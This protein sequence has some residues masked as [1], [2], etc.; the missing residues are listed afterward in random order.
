MVRCDASLHRSLAPRGR[1]VFETGALEK[2]RHIIP[3][4]GGE[5]PE[6]ERIRSHHRR[7]AAPPP[8][9]PKMI[10]TPSMKPKLYQPPLLCTS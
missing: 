9:P 6:L 7:R 10:E 5:R 3:V 1:R 8:L 2:L 4:R